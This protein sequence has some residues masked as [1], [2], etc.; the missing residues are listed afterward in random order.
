M[1]RIPVPIIRNSAQQ[2]VESVDPLTGLIVGV[3]V[4]SGLIV[5][6]GVVCYL[7]FRKLDQKIMALDTKTLNQGN[8]ILRLNNRIIRIRWVLLRFGAQAQYFA[9]DAAGLR[10]KLLS[11]FVR[12]GRAEVK[13]NQLEKR[14]VTL[15]D[16]KQ[17]NKVYVWN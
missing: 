17:V 12:F 1:N 10:G 7:Q 15:E 5:G 13:L 6:V 8:E 16:F 11:A 4:V 9:A 14:I 2:R 3:G